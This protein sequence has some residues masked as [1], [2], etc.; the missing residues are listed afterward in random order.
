VKNHR[1][2]R[3]IG[4][5]VKPWSYSKIN[6]LIPV[7][8]IVRKAFIPGRNAFLSLRSPHYAMRANDAAPGAHH[9]RPNVGIGT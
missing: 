4:A 3:R 5:Q 9:A 1:R 2:R 7:R 8:R 6:D